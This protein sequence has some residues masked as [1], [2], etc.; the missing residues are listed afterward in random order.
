MKSIQKALVAMAAD[1]GKQATLRT[2]QD[3][4]LSL[5]TIIEIGSD[6][7][8]TMAANLLREVNAAIDT[9]VKS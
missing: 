3:I 8:R 1:E 7:E 2:A 4:Q 5:E 9:V 6:I